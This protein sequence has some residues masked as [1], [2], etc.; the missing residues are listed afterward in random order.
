MIKKQD[1]RALLAVVLSIGVYLVWMKFFAPAPPVGDPATQTADAAGTGADAVTATASAE[2][3]PASVPGATTP[4]APVA[5]PPVAEVAVHDHEQAVE[6]TLFE[7]A[8]SSKN[9]ALTDLTL[10][11]F[12]GPPVMTP[13]WS[14]VIEKVSGE[15]EGWSAYAGGDA[16]Q[17]MLGAEGALLLAGVGPLDDDGAGS[18]DGASAYTITQ[19]G[20]ITQAV[21]VIPGVARITK[22]YALADKPYTLDVSVRIDDLSGTG[23]ANTWVGVADRM[24]GEAGRFANA[25]RPVVYVDESIEH[26]YELDD[27]MEEA[28][29]Y[30]GPVGW[31]GVG[32][33]Y[34][35][36][37]LVPQEGTSL[38]PAVRVQ[39]LPGGRFGS[40]VIDG[41][42][43]GNA[44][45][46]YKF[47][48]FVGPKDLDLLGELGHGLDDAVEY[49]IF[50]LFS[51]PLLYLLK[52]FQGFVVN[53][54][55]AI[56]LLTV[57]VKA[58]FFPLNNK[59]YKSSKRMAA[60]QPQLKA[61]KEKYKDDQQMQ[62]QETMRLFKENDVN[63][64]G[65]CLPM[66]VQMPVWF[67]LYNV[68]LYSVELYDTSF[69]IWKDLT[70]AD[71]YGVLPVVYATLM[72]LQ[73]R[74]MPMTT[75]DPTQQ[76]M[77]RAMPLIF[78]FFMFTFP[79]GLVLYFCVN[80][81]L[82]IAQQWLINRNFEKAQATAPVGG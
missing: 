31:F 44:S 21:R 43:D 65:G 52:F 55:L 14:W 60:V 24:S 42:L 51:V 9:G 28:E 63:P 80:M 66:V 12:T 18:A 33:R 64:M 67:A 13:W 22:T 19:E 54:G 81:V 38:P 68:M 49:G 62:T 79:S 59:A 36:S 27:L 77:M 74:S 53:W 35:M 29:V 69:F 48:A 25:P 50:G 26:A 34:F 6:H 41:A 10:R 5:S 47:T 82:T 39:P 11:A 73:Q 32:D 30:E 75:M 76:K 78:S 37:V 58:V 20:G 61:M 56:I 8:V 45:R 72:F 70:A 40:F 46:T 1:Q 17:R 7:G 57:S 4:P 2:P 3:T 71:P 15:A 23:A 16:P